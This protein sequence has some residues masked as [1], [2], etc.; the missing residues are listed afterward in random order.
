MV[1]PEPPGILAHHIWE[2]N[3][4]RASEHYLIACKLPRHQEISI[5]SINER[6]EQGKV[7]GE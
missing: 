4:K 3:L 2:A 1:A 6:L 5:H 7:E